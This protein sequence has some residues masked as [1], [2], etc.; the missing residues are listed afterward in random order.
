ML[1]HLKGKKTYSLVIA[2]ILAAMAGYLSGEMTVAQ[3]V[4]AV[5]I[6]LGLATLRHGVSTEAEKP[7]VIKP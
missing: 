4:E 1:D 7:K 2:G 3:T 6:A 5:L